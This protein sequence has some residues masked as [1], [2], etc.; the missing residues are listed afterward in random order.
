VHGGR[1]RLRLLL[2]IISITHPS[3]VM[4]LTQHASHGTLCRQGS[5]E[6]VDGI[7]GKPFDQKFCVFAEYMASYSYI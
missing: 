3:Y 4:S 5:G 7:Y 6:Q 1:D 2:R